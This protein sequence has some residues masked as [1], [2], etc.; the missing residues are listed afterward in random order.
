MSNTSTHPA[1]LAAASFGAEHANAV[2]SRKVAGAVTEGWTSAKLRCAVQFGHNC[3]YD[4]DAIALAADV[5]N[6]FTLAAT[7]KA[8][9]GESLLSQG[10]KFAAFGKLAVH[11]LTDGNGVRAFG[12]ELLV[13]NIVRVVDLLGAV[14][15]NDASDAEDKAAAKRANTR[16]F[17]KAVALARLA[18]KLGTVNLAEG[19][20]KA[21]LCEG[22]APSLAKALAQ[23][24]AAMKKAK[25]LAPDAGWIDFIGDF[26]VA[27][28]VAKAEETAAKAKADAD[29]RTLE[30]SELVAEAKAARLAA[31]P[32]APVAAA[33]AEISEDEMLGGLLTA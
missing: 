16:V 10:R 13:A 14:A 31:K 21:V 17:E 20:I 32:P 25:I 9:G 15:N 33:P 2:S 1:V 28:T 12:A 3:G 18:G 4:S 19:D 8:L 24:V 11:D 29:R 30:A 22:E 6:A 27:A 5:A 7:G 23:A 26:E